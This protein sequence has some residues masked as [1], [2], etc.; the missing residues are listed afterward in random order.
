VLLAAPFLIAREN[1]FLV[2]FGHVDLLGHERLDRRE[3]ERNVRANRALSL[4]SLRGKTMR[5]MLTLATV[6]LGGAFAC[7]AVAE[8]HVLT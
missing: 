1:L 2:I 6:V 5:K 4:H 8:F 7:E 3:R